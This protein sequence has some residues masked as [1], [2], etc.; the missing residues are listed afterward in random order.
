MNQET[1]PRPVR[2]RLLIPS[3]IFLAVAGP[4]V[5]AGIIYLRPGWFA[6]GQLNHGTLVRPPVKIQAA[7]LPRAFSATPL[8]ADYFRGRWTLVY[9]GGPD[10]DAICKEALYATRQ[11]RLGVGEAMR[12]VQRLYV[13]RGTPDSLAYLHREHPDLTVVEARGE[14]GRRFAA[15]F[16]HVAHDP[17]LYLVA[18]EGYLM[19]TYPAG[20]NPEGLLKD[21]RHLLGEGFQ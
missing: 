13:V 14:T 8:P 15:Q 12:A 10:C 7:A 20:H 19:M 3:L 18:P 4:F 5:I 6:L 16:T 21:L 1:L 9:V 17:S 2:W 11:V